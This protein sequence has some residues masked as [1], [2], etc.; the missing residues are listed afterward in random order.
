[1]NHH[2]VPKF[3][4]REWADEKGEVQ[5][6]RRIR[7][8]LEIR[9]AT[10]AATGYAIDLYTIPSRTSQEARQEVETRFM[11]RVDSMGAAILRELVETGKRPQDSKRASAW[12]RFLMSMINRSP[13]RIRAIAE[14]ARS[15]DYSNLDELEPEYQRRR[16]PHWPPTIYDY[17]AE[18]RM[19]FD[20]EL[21]KG[22]LTRVIDSSR[23]GEVINNLRWA[24]VQIENADWTFLLS[25]APV[26]YGNFK[27]DDAILIMPIGPRSAFLAAKR[28]DFLDALQ[29]KVRTR[30]FVRQLNEDTVRRARDVVI[31]SDRK[32]TRFI[33]NR[34]I[35]DG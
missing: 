23:V 29:H 16:A 22:A 13:Q 17:I 18:N 11:Q 21:A 30:D 2:Y 15:H 24:V 1:M 27:N 8:T 12:T 33:D 28:A 7:G 4:I 6:Y 5:S 35:R 10:P 20:E 26:S 25:D 14:M 32:Q 3:L 19:D 31:A 9:R 34:F